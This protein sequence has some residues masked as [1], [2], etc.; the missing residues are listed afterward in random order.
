LCVISITDLEHPEGV[1]YYNTNG[2]AEDVSV[3]GEYAY[4]ADGYGGLRVLSFADPEHPEEVGYYD[5][6]GYARSV[7]L[8]EDGLIY[9]A[10]HTNMG[11]YRFTPTTIKDDPAASIPVKFNLS[12]AYPNPFNSAIKIRFG[13]PSPSHASLQVYNNFGQQVTTLFEGYKQP[14]IHTITMT[15]NDLPSG[16]YFVRLEASEQVFTQKIILFR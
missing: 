4:V 14:G 3:S 13:L 8:S 12:A 15:A 11:I 10:D 16:L 1:R 7:A 6:P 2:Y 9:V 5:T